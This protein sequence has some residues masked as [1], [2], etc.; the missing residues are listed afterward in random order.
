MVELSELDENK[1]DRIIAHKHGPNQPA[2]QSIPPAH[3]SCYISPEGETVVRQIRQ[4][5]RRNFSEEDIVDIIA[6]YRG[7]KS[8]NVLARIYGCSRHTICNH[9]KKHGVEVCRSKIK[10]EETS[11]KILALYACEQTAAEIAAVI[12]VSATAIQRHLTANGV[13]MRGRWGT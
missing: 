6:A 7:G 5:Q 9:L 1:L 8:A 10:G 2:P 3:D 12:G 4:T 13:K 11:N